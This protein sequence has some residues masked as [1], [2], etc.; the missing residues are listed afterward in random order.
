L[1]AVA[2]AAALAACSDHTQ[3]QFGA[4]GTDGRVA[5]SDTANQPRAMTRLPDAAITAS[6]K[7]QFAR[8][9]QLASLAIEVESSGGQVT[10]TGFVPNSAMRDHAAQVAQAVRGVSTVDNRITVVGG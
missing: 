2:A 6:V 1:T 9:A 4:T 5:Q 8:D 10:L 3:P 7:A